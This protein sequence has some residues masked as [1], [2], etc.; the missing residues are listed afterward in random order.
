MS[1]FQGLEELVNGLS[2]DDVY[3]VRGVDVMRSR[4][5]PRGAIYD[6]LHTAELGS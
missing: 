1:D 4:L 3:R 5:M 2:Y 6:V